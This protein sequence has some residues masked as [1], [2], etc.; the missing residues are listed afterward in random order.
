MDSGDGTMCSW[1]ARQPCGAGP[2][3]KIT[4]GAQNVRISG[5][6]TGRISPSAMDTSN[7]YPLAF[8]SPKGP[9]RLCGDGI[10]TTK[11]TANAFYPDVGR[12]VKAQ[13]SSAKNRRGTTEH[14]EIHLHRTC[15]D[16]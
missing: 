13:P 10:A 4:L 15:Q 6:K 2:V 1:M 8:C 16:D 11:L 14:Y 5:T 9:T 3:L 7:S 12:K